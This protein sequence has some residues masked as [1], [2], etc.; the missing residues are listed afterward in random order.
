M[1]NLRSWSLAVL[2]ALRLEHFRQMELDADNLT[3]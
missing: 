3:V 1:G 2:A